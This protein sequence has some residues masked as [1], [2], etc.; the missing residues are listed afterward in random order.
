MAMCL[1][2]LT[3]NLHQLHLFLALPHNSYHLQKIFERDKRAS[4]LSPSTNDPAKKE[5]FKTFS[6]CTNSNSIDFQ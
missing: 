5:I 6:F 4:L 2:L 1:Y 3:L